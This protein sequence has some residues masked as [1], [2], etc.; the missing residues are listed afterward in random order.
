M[1]KAIAGI[2]L[3]AIAT[4]ANAATLEFITTGSAVGYNL[5]NLATSGSKVAVPEISGLNVTTTFGA[6]GGAV[7]YL[8]A[9]TTQLG[10]NSDLA[11]EGTSYF[12]TDEW[13]AFAFDQDVNVTRFKF[14]NFTAG[15]VVKI[16]W[17]TTVLTL[18][19]ADL[20]GLNEY[21]VDWDVTAADTIRFDA[22]GKS[23][24]TSTA[25][26]FGLLEM[27]VTAVPEPATVS[28]LT[29]SGVLLFVFRRTFP[30]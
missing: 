19:D 16:T 22:L 10:I 2:L 14:A 26:G 11:D 15:D 7:D 9:T 12:D 25:G 30:V 17:D 6:V 18:G 24:P 28:M 20:N 4:L 21:A 1:R 29:I 13:V 5:D 8:N 23:S 27:D 3:I